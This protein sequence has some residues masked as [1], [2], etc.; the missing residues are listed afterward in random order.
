MHM[1]R[2]EDRNAMIVPHRWTKVPGTS[3]VEIY[4]IIRKPS[5]VCSSTYIL[6]TSLL[7][8]IIDPGADS[9]QVEHIREIVM[10]LHKEQ[11]LP[12][13]VMLTHCHVDHFLAMSELMDQEVG[14]QL[15]CHDMTAR[16]IEEKDRTLTMANMIDVALPLFPV[17]ARF[18]ASPGAGAGA[19]PFS[20]REES[21][22]LSEGRRILSQSCPISE[23][24]M[25]EVFHTPGHSPDGVC[26][27]IGL[28]LFSGDLHLATAAGI[29]GLAGW[30]NVA[31]AHS[32]G[33]MIEIGHDRGISM[34]L[35]GH[36]IPLPFEKAVRVFDAVQKEA[37]TLS[38]LA[39]LDRKRADYL[40]EYALVLLEEAGNIFSI[41]AARILKV[42]HYLDLLD[43]QEQAQGIL[44]S[45]DT[46]SIDR[47]VDEFY[48]F[49]EELRGSGGVPLISKAVQF[50]RDVDTIFAP[51]KVRHLFDRFLLHRLN[52][53]LS[54]FV[55]VAYG[56]SFPNQETIFDINLSVEALLRELKQ[57]PHESEKIL[58]FLEDDEGFK[59]EL[60]HRIAHEAFFSSVD[61]EF[62]PTGDSTPVQADEDIFQDTVSTL[63]TQFAIAGTRHVLL[64]SRREE[65]KVLFQVIDN[66][67]KDG[68]ELR[69]SKRSYLGHAMHMAGGRFYET[70]AGDVRY[71]NFEFASTHPLG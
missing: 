3:E 40:S 36:G 21:I 70:T 19:H 7:V 68:M 1:Q 51:E 10:P 4:S 57:N 65:R 58:E 26:Y 67:Q 39:L 60:A 62:V 48:N 66:V 17:S 23:A 14:G 6:K 43:E 37:L 11:G 15:A 71:Y 34:V 22:A 13:S 33:D 5:I 64:R 31:L 69:D 8:I 25:M 63:L 49:A 55:N 29:A 35:P 46:D 16:A 12:V 20:M 38:N 30:D 50:V 54:A 18:F 28:L 41:I 52:S 56:I 59:R 61:L 44:H 45:V 27:K 9:S 2:D 47:I 32:L 42:V 24:D 53:L